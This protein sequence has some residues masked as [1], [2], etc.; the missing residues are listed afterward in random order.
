MANSLIFRSLSTP[1][2]QAQLD[3]FSQGDPAE[4]AE[5]L[6]LAA[7]G[8]RDAD[9]EMDQIIGGVRLERGGV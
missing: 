3:P 1:S 5:G 8:V 4:G 7:E 6:Q 9:I 2:V